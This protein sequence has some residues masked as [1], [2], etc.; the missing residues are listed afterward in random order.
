MLARSVATCVALASPLRIGAQTSQ[1]SLDQNEPQVSRQL[2]T[3][4]AP[5]AAGRIGGSSV[6]TVGQRQTREQVAS[7]ASPMARIENRIANRV[8]SRIRNRI[9]RDY[10]PQANSTSPFATAEER[11]RKAGRR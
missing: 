1:T 9:D 10:D 6:G 4:P 8:Q 2:P 3:R 5:V 7:D 11:T